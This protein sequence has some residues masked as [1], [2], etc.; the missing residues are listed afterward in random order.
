VSAVA[1]I[2]VSFPPDTT[3]RSRTPAII[4]AECRQAPFVFGGVKEQSNTPIRER[5][6]RASASPERRLRTAL[7][8][9]PAV[10]G[11]GQSVD[12]Y[13]FATFSIATLL[14][15]TA[16]GP[17]MAIVAHNTLRHGTATGLLTVVGVELGELC[18]LTATF[19]GV[20][21]S[22]EFFPPLFRWLG[23]A[24]T[25]YLLWLAVSALRAH[26]APVQDAIATRARMPVLEG[27]MVAAANPAALV[28]Y[29][30]F[31]PQFLRPD[32][33]LAQQ[34]IALG[35]VYLFTAIAFDLALVL[36]LGRIPVPASWRRF[37]SALKF[38]STAVYLTI[39]IFGVV[40][41]VRTWA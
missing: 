26:C 38:A 28:F 37:G 16:P 1:G 17:V 30:A 21:A 33:P 29:T 5:P 34:T 20:T 25:L 8:E 31:F 32:R 14:V 2:Y 24:G 10:V 18:L 9:I 27:L 11:K 39:A 40:G 6:A 35:A 13:L 3:L 23:L 7:H 15:V 12:W 4:H 41:F 22:A 36:T 19:M